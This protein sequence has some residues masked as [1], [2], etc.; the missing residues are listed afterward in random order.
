[1]FFCV[2]LWFFKKLTPMTACEV[3]FDGLVG[4]THNFAGLSHGNVASM[5]HAGRVSHPRAAALQGLAKMKALAD[6]GVPQAVLPPHERPAIPALRDLGFSGTEAQVLAAAA[7]QAPALLA[8]CS[9]SSA[10]WVANAATVSP[11]ADTP[12]GRVHFTP[13]NLAAKLHRSLE[14]AQTA[15]TL[16]A[17]FRDPRLFI[18]HEPV[19]GAGGMGDEGAA[20]HLRF[21]GPAG[22]PGL[23]VFVYGHRA[24][25]K[26]TGSRTRRFASR[27]ALE[28]SQAVAR[29]HGLRATRTLF[30]PQNPAAIDAGAFHNDVVA[31][32]HENFLFCHEQAFAGG[33]RQ[34]AAEL[35]RRFARTHPGATL[36]CVIV[37]ARR[38]PLVA[39]VRTYLFN[40]QIVTLPDCR[41]VLIAPAEVR[42]DAR[43]RGFVEELVAARAPAIGGIHYFDLRQSMD[44]GG[45]P[46][47]LRLRVT[48]TAAERAA[49]PPSIWIND[50]T[51]PQ[52]VAWVQKHYREKLRPRDLAE[53]QLLQESRRALDEL[54]RLLGLGSIFPFQMA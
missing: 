43:V 54:T 17:I 27:Q 28:A 33:T 9:S 5:R 34:V 14:P 45:G 23:N 10:M 44:N 37:P 46:A 31:V 22:R 48:L 51:Y 39:A 2:H 13:A 19:P 25:E 4:P 41:R 52:L 16:G 7:K 12:D 6:L 42:A 49:L 50:S 11:S 36:A 8:A 47:C 24:F 32:A 29:Q 26:S 18:I 15:R 40:S 53:P 35:R 1:M 3:N 30:V 21:D 20:N 38:V